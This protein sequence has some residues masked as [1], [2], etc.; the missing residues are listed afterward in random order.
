MCLFK[1]PSRSKNEYWI[2]VAEDR[3]QWRAF[4]NTVMNKSLQFSQ[5]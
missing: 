4:V 5:Q 2:K 1:N 3:V